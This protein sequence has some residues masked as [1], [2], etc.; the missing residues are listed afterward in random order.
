MKSSLHSLIPLL[1]SFSIILHWQLS[2]FSAATANSEFDSI[3]ILE[4]ER[5]RERERELLYDWWFSSNQFVL[6]PSPLRHTTI[7]LFRLNTCGYSPYAISSLTRVWVCRLQLLL[8][9]A[10][11]V[12]LRSECRGTHDHILLSQIRDSPNAPYLYPPGIG[13]PS[14]TSIG[15]PFRRLLRLASSIVACWFVAARMCLPSCCLAMYVSSDFTIPALGRHV[16]APYIMSW[17]HDYTESQS[18]ADNFENTKL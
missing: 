13:W 5:E 2:Q 18:D 12:I 6:A 4:R 9:L 16:T 7:I 15:F 14:Y 10:S 17:S 8:V 11:A 1:P 3:L